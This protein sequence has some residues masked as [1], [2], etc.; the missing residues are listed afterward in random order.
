MGKATRTTD[1][2]LPILDRDTTIAGT[3]DDG[4]PIIKK[5]SAPGDG[6]PAPSGSSPN[7][8]QTE[9]PVGTGGSDP[10]QVTANYKNNV[11][12]PK[13]I[14]SK[15]MPVG[16]PLEQ[17]SSAINNK[18]KNLSDWSK[19]SSDNYVKSLV[20][21]HKDV[22]DKIDLI[23]GRSDKMVP[24]WKDT[25]DAKDLG[26]LEK[27]EKY[28]RGQIQKSYDESKKKAVPEIIDH[29]KSVVGVSDWVDAYNKPD[30]DV[31]GIKM[32]S[33]LQWN[34]GTHKLTPQSTEWVIKQVDDQLNKKGDAAINAAVS[35]DL[36]KKDRTYPD[37]SKSVVDYLNT[38]PVQKKQKEY[39]DEFANR[40]PE[41]KDAFNANKEVNEFFSKDKIADLNA[42]V[43][44]DRDKDIVTTQHKYFGKGGLA[45]QNK[46]F[47]DIQEK[48]AKLVGEGKM[49]DEVARKQ[50]E[51]ELKQNPSLKSLNDNYETEIR[52]ITEKTQKQFGDYLIEGLKKDK[53][54]FTIYKDG[55]VGLS[56]MD[57]DKYK[58][59][60]KRYEGGLNDI[61]VGMG[62]DSN[63]AWQK[64]A[65][66][67]AKSVGAFWGSVGGSMNDM[68]SA[69]SKYVFNK[70]QWGAKDVRYYESQD[71]SSPQIEQSKISASWN[72]KGL[73]SLKDPN[74][75]LSKAGSMV[76][77]IAGASAVGLA[78]DG[79]GMPE[80]VGWLAN[81]G[82]FTAQNG[83]STY[84]QLL[85][86]RDAQ[87]NLLTEADASHYMSQQMSEDF[88]PNVLMMAVTS[89]TLFKA[90][91]IIKPTIGGVIKKA[92]L[93]TAEAQPFFTWQGY[94]DYSTAQEAQGKKT[95]FWDYMQSKDF[96][97]N[98]INGMI[99]GGGLSL[100]HAPGQYMKSVDNW[101]KMVHMSE[102][103]FKNL[104]PQ[105]YALGQEFAGNGNA[106]R[107]ALK[108]H[109][110]NVDPDGLNEEGRRNLADL[111]A[112]LLYSTN[113]E[114]NIRQGNLDPKNITELYQAHNLA[115]ADQHDHLSEQATK[116]GNKSLSDIY[117]GKA[118]DY[119][120]QAKAA[121]GDQAKFHYLV[122]SEGHPIFLSDRSFKTLEQ[123][124]T[125]AKWQKDGTIEGVHKSDDPEFAQRYKEFVAAKDEA[126]VEGGEIMD[127]AKGLIEENKDKL[128]VYYSAAKKDPEQF[129]K[130]VADQSFGR[131]ADGS[132]S[133]LPNSEQAARDQY[134]NDIV[135][136]AKLMY[137]ET[138][139]LKPQ[140][141]KTN[142]EPKE[143]KPEENQP[144]GEYKPNI[145]DDYFAKADFFTPEEK[146]KFAT[147]DDPGKDKM[148]DDKRA[149]L[150]EKSGISVIN[151]S[152]VK[153]PEIVPLVKTEPISSPKTSS[154]EKTKE[155]ERRQ[156][157]VLIPKEEPVTGSSETTA[158]PSIPEPRIPKELPKEEFTAV[159]KE[160]QKEIKGAKAL[161]N[162][163]K[164]IKWTETY[165][166][167]L[168]HLQDMYPGKNIYDAAKS[169]VD[170][171]VTKLENGDLFNPTSEDIAVFNYFKDET[172]RRMSE[173]PGMGS[174]DSIQRMA[175]VAEFTALHNDLLN[176]IK[177]NNPG[178]EAGRAFNL[179]RSEIA[180]DPEHGLQ[181][182]RMELLAAKGG[183]KLT[184]ADLDFTSENWEKE[185]T[186][187]E[188][189]NDLKQKGMQEK[190]DKEMAKVKADYEKRLKEARADRKPSQK[191]KREKLLSEKG[192]EFA[193]KIR[194]GKLKGTYATFPGLPQAINFVLESIAKIVEKGSTLAQ[195]IDEFVK[196]HNI[197]NKDQFQ[198]DLFEVFTKQERQGDAYAKIQKLSESTGITDVTNEMVGK[199][200]IRDFID[201][202]VGLHE[203]KDVLDISHSELQKIL[204]DLEKDR[205]R[206]AYLKQ[207]EF[208]Q[209]TKKELE[210]GFKE[211]QRNFERLTSIEKDIAD[212]TNKGELFKKSNPSR[213]SPYDKEIEAKENEKKAIMD[214]MGI[215]TARE[216]KYKKA[217]YVQRAKAHNDRIDAVNADIQEKIDKG[218]LSEKNE[219]ALIKL[220][221]QLDASKIKI[222]PT[223][224][225]SQE[226]T[227]EGGIALM[228]SLK[229]EFQR[230]AD[231][232]S[233]VGD[234]NRG[235]QR[236]ID[237]FGTDKDDSEQ[238]IKLQRAKDQAKRDAEAIF[239]KISN[240]EYEDRPPV[241]LTKTDA[242]LIKLERQR[243]ALSQLYK[244]K[245]AEYEKSGKPK[246]K[247]W[248]EIAR[249]AMVTSLIWKPFTLAKV[250]TSALL[251]PSF[252]AATKLT[253]GKGFEALPISTTKAISERAKAGGESNSIQSIKKGYEAYLRQYSPKQIEG[254]YKTANDN[255]EKSNKAYIE[256]QAEVD[257]V[258]YM[259]KDKP[260]YE[261]AVAKLGELNNK[262]DED[263]VSAVGNSMYQFIGGSSMK[264]ALEV[265]LHRS[266]TMERQ[267]GD[268]EREDFD[269]KNKISAD[270]LGYLLNFV[271]RSH[272]A[273]KNY[274][275]RFS[276]A[277]GFMARLES[278]VKNDVD[279]TQPDKILEIAHDSYHDW[280]RGKYQ[281]SN[282]ITDKWNKATNAVEKHSPQLAYLL[283]S[284]V[285]ITRV[286]VNMLREG[287]M[288]YTLGAF[289]GSVNAAREYYKA[290][291][292]VL[293]D[294]LTKEGTDQFREELKE[295]LQK[296]DAVKAAAIMRSFRKGGF[297]LGL[298]SLA[299]L[300]HIAFGG[301][302]HK[303]Q[304][305]EDTKKTKRDQEDDLDEIKTGE[306]RIGNWKMPETFAKIAEHTPAFAPLGFG[307]GLAQVYGNSITEGKSTFESAYDAALGQ[308]NHITGSIP[309]IDKVVLPL[310]KGVVDT[311]LPSGQW[312]DVDQDGN[313]MKRKAFHISDYLNYLP[314]F[315]SKKEVLSENYYKQAVG[316][317]K[318]YREQ[319]TEVE[320]NTSLSKKE[321]DDQREEL[322]KQMKLDIDDVYIQNKE[323][324]Q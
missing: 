195:A 52:K 215:K 135:N 285:A 183:A 70:T 241:E 306:I 175:A 7:P 147:L 217:S 17:I 140:A 91:N 65:D 288:E 225:L 205:L 246:I 284:D 55:T 184:Q 305:A 88:L 220:K 292:I 283:R 165:D 258:K 148:I 318:S 170:H 15:P 138:E 232:I 193:A 134:G 102:G 64:E 197:K 151:P 226:K 265:L 36:D 38:I 252:E 58:N 77:V 92:L 248:A 227:L 51:A 82:L 141:E 271:G 188:Q 270:N 44:I 224:A 112:G 119:R 289:T 287:I 23:N 41:L 275:A 319:I 201:S 43:N 278:A 190:F 216:D 20:D 320:I 22:Q 153:H 78:T 233:K 48:Y 63:E 234:I 277:S 144:S 160:K 290:K 49:T 28:Y 127:H 223:S 302:A 53:P 293:Q 120:E 208:K 59:L 50:V 159:R 94:N 253:F 25:Q 304:T 145:R 85:N 276:F 115:L 167:A 259:G 137:P 219:K 72:W 67:K 242:E 57:E 264:E 158:P 62:M 155:A 180:Q 106:L 282:W 218:G 266:T 185:R 114:R 157:D 301:W 16:P 312:D 172:K 10:K 133:D 261:Q 238:N 181:I 174:D 37:I 163:Q 13:D 324:P 124:G 239:R 98:L 257:R 280:E 6:S 177:V 83:L 164:V 186:L 129:Y 152:E 298:Y 81:A 202:H 294:G 245:Q 206:E 240:G 117:S 14:G 279:I 291:G 272:A 203:P 316:I 297:G 80:Y 110:F 209:P 150:K 192:A 255:Y 103:E 230:T 171:F 156:G 323:N 161:F 75:W 40:H 187:M 236:L 47:V 18:G 45:Y 162:K 254:L 310:A 295:Q 274:S 322:L 251:R 86:T 317:Q 104:I 235:V 244:N 101:T 267:F 24:A 39:T 260:E 68:A 207:G 131:N 199:N 211:S 243:G 122:N 132:K 46:D 191:E 189:E 136:V 212:L 11:L 300:G 173:I 21:Q 125:I 69:F 166:N 262:R 76:P 315:G 3:T 56:G 149:E 105:N 321:K 214:V 90:K 250:A 231:D 107:D 31:L 210:S 296:I 32:K 221:N 229:S 30:Q 268:F 307:L 27:S 139:E 118:K 79:A 84:N 29:L 121:A 299:L 204:P 89:G 61:A 168:S 74:F 269:K 146:E 196:A 286:P 109:I 35:G 169:R 178:G 176:I 308:V 19:S 228:K 71:I 5:K 263:L 182:R 128:G 66:K 95:D 60:I 198:S 309:Q 222:D 9:P 313:P 213:S 314:G 113:L 93:G 179:L 237:K 97:D 126:T 12:T 247:R 100:L 143:Q 281:E 256:Q 1:D 54:K 2:G 123:E 108:L 33:P 111:K 303:G 26:D 42:K 8:N 249:G 99:V 96:K 273:L 142:P 130:A 154:D 311:Y 87:G 200:L 194:A 4:L 116:E 34:P 73:E